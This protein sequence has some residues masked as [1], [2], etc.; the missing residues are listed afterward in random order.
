[1]ANIF[2]IARESGVSRSTVSRVINNQPGVKAEKREAVQKAIEKLHYTPSAAARALA[3]SKTDTIAVVVKELSDPFYSEFI[4]HIHYISDHHGY[5]AIYCHR[6]NNTHAKVDYLTLL[7]GQVDGYIFIGEYTATKEE[8]TKLVKSGN[9]VETIGFDM[10]VEGVSS[11]TVDNEQGVEDVMDHLVEVGHTNIVY[12]DAEEDTV[13]FAQRRLGYK[14]KIEAYNLDYSRVEVFGYDGDEA[15][16]KASHIAKTLL[17]EGVTSVVCFNDKIA[18]CFM[19]GLISAGVKVPEQI[20]VVGFDDVTIR[21]ISNNYIP[22]LTTVAQ[23][24]T[25]MAEHA[26]ARFVESIEDKKKVTNKV[27]K[28]K[29]VIRESCQ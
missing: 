10:G 25:D 3:K 4:R 18:T 20:S 19:D 13:E 1:M 7:N 21:R 23:P 28:C 6:N 5:G 17:D 11:I 2:D 26:V 15:F 27:F 14:E 16:D 12:V 24:H 9:V 8:L 22:T 29:L